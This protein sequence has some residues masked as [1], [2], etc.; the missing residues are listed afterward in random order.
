KPQ[1]WVAAFLAA[2]I[3][4]FILQKATKKE[5]APTRDLS[6]QMNNQMMEENTTELTGEQ[7]VSNF[8]C[9]NCH[10]GNLQGTQLAPA[11]TNLSQY[12]GKDNLISYLRNPG[13]Y[14]NDARFQD[15]K[16]KY[17][18]QIMPSYGNKNIKD[19]GKIVD[20]LLER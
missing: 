2:F 18:S 16:Q 12:W 15:Y 20:Y 1:I 17:P 5:E 4:L 3:L 10:G 9:T 8:G 6:S 7:L 19:L 13:D 14:M 11:L